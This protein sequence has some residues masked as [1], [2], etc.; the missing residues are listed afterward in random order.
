[1]IT[2]GSY[3]GDKSDVWSIG[4]IMLELTLG[5]ALTN[6]VHRFLCEDFHVKIFIYRFC[7]KI[8]GRYI[9]HQL[10]NLII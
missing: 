9:V 5:T 10:I 3:Y 8:F 1:M 2:Q 4:G 7:R 6:F